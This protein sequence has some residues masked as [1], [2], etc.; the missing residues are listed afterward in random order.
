M[1]GVRGYKVFNPDWTCRGKKYSCPGTFEEDVKLEVCRRGIHFCKKI[2]S[3]FDYYK[4]NP[5]NKVAE[6]VAYG[7]VITEGNKSVTNKLE[8]VREISWKEVLELVNIGET[9]SGKCNSG[10]CN[11]GDYNSGNCNRGSYNSGSYNSGYWNSGS[12]NSGKSN[13]GDCNSGSYN[14]GNYNSGYYN[15]GYCNSGN[16]NSGSANS[17]NCNSGKCN[18]GDFNSGDFNS[19]SWNSGDWNRCDFSNGCFNTEEPKIYLFNKPTNWTYTD[20]INSAAKKIMQGILSYPIEYVLSRDMTDE[21][22]VEHPEAEITGGY[23]KESYDPK[24][25]QDWWNNLSEK[26]RKAVKSLP[27]FDAK[28]FKEITGIE[29]GKDD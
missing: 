13:S 5:K 28:I 20:W 14:S 25:V 29:V 10:D 7:K 3:C 24:K 9:C 6:V 26:E 2:A 11:S 16:Y 1:N 22:K 23:L 18:S 17:G 19:G 21:E 4:F 8:I 15:S 12:R 27:N